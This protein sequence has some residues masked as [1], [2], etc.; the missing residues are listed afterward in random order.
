M[1]F[2]MIEALLT[3]QAKSTILRAARTVPTP[4]V[5]ALVGTFLKPSKASAASIRVTL[6]KFIIR[7]AELIFEPGSLNPI[8]PV[9]PIP[10]S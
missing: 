1:V 7:V 4:I 2:L 9:L 5:I 6:F 3:P 10:S 8:C